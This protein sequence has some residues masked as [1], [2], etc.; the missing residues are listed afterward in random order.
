LTTAA[1][2]A[3]IVRMENDIVTLCDSASAS[4]N[5]LSISGAYNLIY[6][7]SL[8][9]RHPASAAAVRIKFD[10]FEHGDHVS[11]VL[12]RL[13]GPVDRHAAVNLA[14]LNRLRPRP[15]SET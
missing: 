1:K 9:Y 11:R 2:N 14:G 5:K 13:L 8:P 3:L 15:K 4:G 7:S 12:H 6:A 10:E